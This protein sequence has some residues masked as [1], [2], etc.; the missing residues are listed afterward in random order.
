MTDKT[1]ENQP[2]QISESKLKSNLYHGYLSD[3][4][5]RVFN[6]YALTD[7]NDPPLPPHGTTIR[8]RI[9]KETQTN[10]DYFNWI[11]QN[12]NVMLPETERKAN[13]DKC[14]SLLITHAFKTDPKIRSAL[15]NVISEALGHIYVSD[16]LDPKS[17]VGALIDSLEINFDKFH[18]EEL[19]HPAVRE[20]KASEICNTEKVFNHLLAKG[21][22]EAQARGI[23]ANI[24]SECQA[25][26]VPDSVEELYSEKTA[27]KY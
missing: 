6:P 19:R 2:S 27:K 11:V 13:R 26:V 14:L 21:F 9:V 1:W 12:G 4:Y 15:A 25:V 8:S 18:P 5:L 24:L 3:E 7:E 10:V 17:M 23:M 20:L 16:S 22:S